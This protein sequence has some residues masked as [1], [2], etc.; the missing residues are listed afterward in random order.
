MQIETLILYEK[1]DDAYE[2]A[3]FAS[4][5]YPECRRIWN[6]LG[7]IYFKKKEYEKCIRSLNNIEIDKKLYNSYFIINENEDFTT[8]RG[9]LNFLDIPLAYEKTKKSIIS[10]PYK[11]LLYIPSQIDIMYVRTIFN[12]RKIMYFTHLTKQIFLYPI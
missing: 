4:V 12:N 3:K 7:L 2:I 5:L 11:D 8:I 10:I 9:Y 1:I 6:N